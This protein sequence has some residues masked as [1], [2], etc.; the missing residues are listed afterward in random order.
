MCVKSKITLEHA[1]SHHKVV[2]DSINAF[3]LAAS[4]VYG[5]TVVYFTQP[6]IQGV[7][8]EEWKKDGFC[9]QNIDVPFWSSFDTCLYVDIFFSAILGV[10]YLAWKN[11]PGME[12]S[13]KIVPSFIVATLG[14]GIAHGAMAVKFRDGS[15]H[16]QIDDEEANAVT[17]PMW[18]MIAR[19]AVFWFPL[20]KASMPKLKNIHVSFL[21]VIVTYGRG[22]V[23]KELEFA[24]VQTI[25][26]VALHGS[27]LMLATDEKYRREY[28]TLPL[29]GVLPIV[30]AWNEILFCESYFRSAGGHVLYDASIIV[31]YIVFYLNCYHFNT[32]LNDKSLIKQ[33]TV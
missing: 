27:Q 10:M 15:Y 18:Q 29:A 21:A 32:K 19:C 7:V 16:Q 9:I 22:F 14:H 6:G 20:L 17:P 30:M 26:N 1:T 12:T 8:D 25:V 3:V 5:L 31:S 13:S 4:L 33:K 28:M 11:I 23:K 24:Y 2:G